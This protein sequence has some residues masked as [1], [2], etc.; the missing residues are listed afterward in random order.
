MEVKY[1]P[2]DIAEHYL[3]PCTCLCIY[4]DSKPHDALGIV[5]QIIN[6]VSDIN[7]RTRVR[8]ETLWQTRPTSEILATQRADLFESHKVSTTAEL[9]SDNA[10]RL[11]DSGKL[12]GICVSIGGLLDFDGFKM[13]HG[14]VAYE[15]DDWKIS[16]EDNFGGF[17]VIL[18][19]IPDKAL[20]L[21]VLIDKDFV[22]KLCDAAGVCHGVIDTDYYIS[23]RHGQYYTGPRR[24]PHLPE[25][26]RAIDGWAQGG[27][28]RKRLCRDP[29]EA[30]LLG[31]DLTETLGLQT[32]EGAARWRARHGFEPDAPEIV[33]LTDGLTLIKCSPDPADFSQSVRMSPRVRALSK[34]LFKALCDDGV[35]SPAFEIEHNDTL[36]IR[37]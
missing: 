6:K 25:R 22:G 15:N 14:H 20:F 8:A 12:L 10:H 29:R 23:N 21:S 19:F 33:R 5:A 3:V 34:K 37:Y 11:F 31:R 18:S 26:E 7:S 28:A 32:D 24:S 27:E 13:H 17:R 9:F 2:A 35:S 16:P 30:L 36:D 4:F 1:S